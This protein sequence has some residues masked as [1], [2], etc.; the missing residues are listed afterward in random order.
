MAITYSEAITGIPSS[1][2]RSIGY[3]VATLPVGTVG[4][5]AHVTDAL[6]PALLAGLTGGGS[7]LTPVFRN[8]TVWVVG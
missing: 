2:L 7:V 4:D 8:A 5:R 1:T 3:T 6:A